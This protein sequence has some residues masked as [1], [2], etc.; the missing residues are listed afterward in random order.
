MHS[1]RQP[2]QFQP[3][4]ALG[5]DE[6]LASVAQMLDRCIGGTVPRAEWGS[7]GLAGLGQEAISIRSWESPGK[8]SSL[9]QFESQGMQVTL[10]PQTDS[11]A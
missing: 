4:P 2:G 6:L 7:Q 8:I 3:L 11:L 9:W 10:V 5:T 1:S